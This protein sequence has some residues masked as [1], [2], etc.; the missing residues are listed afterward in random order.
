MEDGTWRF[1][2]VLTYEK[3]NNMSISTI[4]KSRQIKTTV[5]LGRCCAI[6]LPT[7][8]HAWHMYLPS[9]W[10]LHQMILLLQP[11]VLGHPSE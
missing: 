3:H 7:S 5:M 8:P 9:S 6:F 1:D 2:D 4:L 11:V 10:R